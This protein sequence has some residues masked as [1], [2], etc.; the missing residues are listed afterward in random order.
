MPASNPEQSVPAISEAQL[1]EIA[2]GEEREKKLSFAGKLATFNGIFVGLFAFVAFASGI[3]DGTSLILALPLAAIA[4]VELGGSK[5]L[6]RYERKG[7]V[8]LTYNQAALIAVVGVYSLV[9]IRT[10]MTHPNPLGQLITE[11]AE[12]SEVLGAEGVGSDFDELYR[13]VTTMFY[14]VVI[15]VT[16]L[17]QGACAL[18]YWTRLKHLDAFLAQTPAWVVEWLR[19]RKKH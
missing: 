9:Q 18:Y 19:A 11:S 8:M 17:S 3:F 2:R 14:T 1:I 13:S 7:L 5:Q 16:A 4:F 10:A 6:A 15:I 12:L